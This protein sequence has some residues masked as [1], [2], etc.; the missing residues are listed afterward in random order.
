MDTDLGLNIDLFNSRYVISLESCSK[1]GITVI[2]LFGNK[3]PILLP[4]EHEK[5]EALKDQ[6]ESQW[7]VAQ[8]YFES[9]GN[10]MADFQRAPEERVV[11]SNWENGTPTEVTVGWQVVPGSEGFQIIDLG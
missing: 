3:E 1:Y 11:V 10:S 6:T 5:L 2:N 9:N 4:I 7:S 8:N